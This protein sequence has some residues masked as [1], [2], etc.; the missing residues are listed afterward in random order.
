MS[1]LDWPRKEDFE[2]VYRD[3]YLG[4]GKPA[5]TQRMQIVENEF[6]D[7][8]DWRK[9][10]LADM[11]WFKRLMVGTI[12]TAVVSGLATILITLARGIH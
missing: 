12:V 10:H 2:R 5:L 7:L 11:K 1:E 9:E 6:D 3:M 4:N 8:N